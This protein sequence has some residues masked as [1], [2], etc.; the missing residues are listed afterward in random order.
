MRFASCSRYGK[1]A[2]LIAIFVAAS[3]GA[4]WSQ[5]EDLPSGRE[6]VDR[7]VEAIGGEKAIRAVGA[8]HM[9][10]VMEV[11][12]QGI[13]ADMDIYTAPSNRML[14]KIEVPAMGSI[15][16]GFDGEVAWSM[17][18]MTGPMVLEGRELDQTRQQADDLALLHPEHLVASLETVEKI[19][20]Q[21]TT[22]YK[23]KVTTTWE[24]EY[25]EYFD[26][27]SGLMVGGERTQS[28]SMGEIPVTSIVS[29]YKQF[30]DLLVATKSV[31]QMMGM[32]QI[33]TVTDLEEVELDPARFE[34]PAEIK[35]MMEGEQ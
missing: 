8:Q 28:S 18:P 4:A 14:V 24:E 22:C 34:L 6:V 7:Y 32:E 30:G 25:F 11:P 12:A 26:V 17:N 3:V 2:T 5:G 1:S 35:A 29:D 19:D 15:S 10:A 16:S 23:V 9:T 31:Q 20:F 21:G 13:S 27:E 33:I